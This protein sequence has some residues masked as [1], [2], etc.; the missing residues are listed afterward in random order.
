MNQNQ[1]YNIYIKQLFKYFIL[2]LYI[3]YFYL[4]KNTKTIMKIGYLPGVFDLLHHGHINIINKTIEACDITVVGIH[5]DEFVAHYKRRPIQTENERLEAVQN[6]FG[7]KIHAFEIVGSNHFELIKKYDITH[8]FHGTDW[9]LTSYKK[10][11]R[12]YEDGLD[13]LNIII[14]LVPYTDGISTTMIVSNL[15]AFSNLDCV[16]FDLDNTL[17]LN[18]A[19][20]NEA[21]ECVEF[22][23]KQNIKIKVVTNN[24]NYTP[25]QISSK[26]CSVGIRIHEDQICSPLKQ[27]K[28]FLTANAQY[29]NVYVWGSDNTVQYF[30]EHNFNVIDKEDMNVADIFIVLYHSNFHY[31]DLSLLVTRIQKHNV[32]YIVGNIDLTYPD[33]NVVLP[34]T[35]SIYKLINSITNISPILMCGKPF[36]NGTDATIDPDKKYLLVG[37]SL[38]TDGKLAENLKIPFYHKTDLFDLGILL[39]KLKLT[40]HTI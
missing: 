27:I 12:Y 8:I 40:Y 7:S 4:K 21:V 2:Y 9:E 20:T 22:I 14:E 36:L 15:E 31:C 16:F 11:I 17:L 32:P 28:N 30:R 13:K 3:L 18:D 38:L 19:P 24:N 5:T 37:D 10:Q 35:G 25:Q 33:K 39:K 6:Y 23:Q 34:D 1:K 26:L 29:K